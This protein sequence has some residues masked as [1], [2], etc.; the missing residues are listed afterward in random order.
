MKQK[1][2]TLFDRSNIRQ[3]LLNTAFM[4]FLLALFVRFI[5]QFFSTYS[6][7]SWYISEFLIN[8]QGG[9]VRRGL[10]GEILFFFVKNFTIN[11]EWTIKIISLICFA[12][13]CVFFV[14]SF[15][16]K[17]YSL[18]I[19]PLCFFLG[20]AILSNNWIRKDYLCLC[21]LIPILW[22]YNKDNLS[23]LVKYLI[24]NVLA[25]FII[26]NHEVFAFFAL[27]ILFLLL[28]N[29]HKSKGTLQSI[30]LSLL[31]LLPCILAF[32]LT[33]VKHGDNEIAQAIWNSWCTLFN[34]EISEVKY[35]SAI[36]AIGWT[37]KWALAFHFKK[38][39]LAIDKNIL[40]LLIWCITFPIIY[41]IATNA[42]LVFRKNENSFTNRHKTALSSILIF[43]LAC[44]SPVLIAL[45]CDYLRIIFYWTASS[46]AV[47]LLIPMNK[48]EQLFPVVF[49]NFVERTNQLL[50]NILRPSKTIL[51]FLMMFTGISGFYCVI[52]MIYKSTMLYNIL[53]VL[54]LPFILLKYFLLHII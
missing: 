25:V 49:I 46:F 44:L 22:L 27:P 30:V 45:S 52:E 41:Y 31:C 37:S 39:F 38:N 5:K 36:G 1:I 9:F 53:W 19:L 48:T 50:T 6:Y 43:Q 20:G 34:Q 23:I 40:S 11:V 14:R 47:F 15:L 8:Y 51:V 24:I 10:I 26:L 18:Y 33:L 35:Q 3:T 29:Q 28:F 2:Q 17:G 54:S 42:L 21:C 13:V 32:L 16:K 7:E 4:L 12:A